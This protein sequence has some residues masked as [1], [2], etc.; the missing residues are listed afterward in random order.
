MTAGRGSFTMSESHYD[1]VPHDQMDKVIA[2]SP[3]KPPATEED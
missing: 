2:A 1:P 3:N